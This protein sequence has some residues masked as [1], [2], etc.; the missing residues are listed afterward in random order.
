[1]G[2]LSRPPHVRRAKLIAREILRKV[3]AV[4]VGQEA[5]EEGVKSES[6]DV[7]GAS[8]IRKRKLHHGAK[9]RRMQGDDDGLLSHVGD[10][11]LAI[12]TMADKGEGNNGVFKDEV[13][14]TV[15]E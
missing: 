15:K 5:D 11:S 10:M 4:T 12:C 13:E 14:G 1:M 2:D 3:N 9:R 6:G 8:G 7:D